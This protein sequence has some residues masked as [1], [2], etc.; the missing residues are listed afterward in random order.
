M[1]KHFIK[2][3]NAEV[4]VEASLIMS[5]AV[6]V[7]FMLMYLNFITYHQ[8]LITTTANQ[9]ATNI[10]Q[11]Y[12]NSFKD[13]VTGYV[14]VSNLDKEG[15]VNKMK[16]EAYT[17]IITKDAEWYSK[18][19][20]IKGQFLKAEE[21]EVEVRI[22]NKNGALLRAQV[23]VDIKEAYELPFVR[24]FGIDNPMIEY[25]ATGRAD[26]YEIMDYI[27][28]IE[29]EDKIDVTENFTV[30]FYNIGEIHKEV[31]VMHDLSIEETMN[32]SSAEK[33]R[34]PIDPTA[35]GGRFYRWKTA[36]GETFTKKT[37]VSGNISVYAEYD[38]VVRFMDLN[39]TTEIARR[40]AHRNK[41][42]KDGGESIPET[43][44]YGCKWTYNNKDFNANTVIPDRDEIIVVKTCTHPSGNRR[45]GECIDSNCENTVYKEYCTI[46]G[47]YVRNSV[48]HGEHDWGCCNRTHNVQEYG[49]PLRKM[50]AAHHNLPVGGYYFRHLICKKCFCVTHDYYWCSGHY[51]GN[52]SFD[53]SAFRTY[54]KNS[55]WE[56]KGIMTCTDP[57]YFAKAEDYQNISGYPDPYAYQRS[58]HP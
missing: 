3:E 46:C 43:G 7:I 23:V 52:G 42:F 13:P 18:Y 58:S 38:C 56:G 15:I 9:T 30:T 26:C 39:G 10:A 57:R 22:E 21:P 34:F 5:I 45:R 40:F 12:S 1:K 37:K 24:F 28:I 51:L 6:I 55:N 17:E 14:D 16:S 11:V 8:T 44:T 25:Q 32:L 35:S 29:A 47:K 27:N 54:Q 31:E 50:C 49:A 53:Y 36:L 41:M 33:T 19:S 4:M 2:S 48:E 20:M